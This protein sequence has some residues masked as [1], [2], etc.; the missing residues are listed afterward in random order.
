MAFD[1]YEMSSS[2]RKPPYLAEDS[3]PGRQDA[4]TESVYQQQLQEKFGLVSMIG[5]SCTIMIT[6]EG[7]LFVYQ[8][9]MIDGGPLG[10]IIGYLFCWAGYTLVALCLVSS[11]T[12]PSLS[13]ARIANHRLQAELNSIFPTAGGQY[14]KCICYW[15]K[16]LLLISIPKTGP[17]SLRLNSGVDFSHI[18]PDGY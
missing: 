15:T 9:G 13:N 18:S 11:S 8:D 17:T 7:F 14:R 6:W 16:D 1:S 3:E 2:E 4:T 12:T 10:S 5:F